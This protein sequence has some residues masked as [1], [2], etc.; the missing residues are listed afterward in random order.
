MKV[1]GGHAYPSVPG[2]VFGS[3]HVHAMCVDATLGVTLGPGTAA[4]PRSLSEQGIAAVTEE[5]AA[6]NVP[7]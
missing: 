2:T 1:I 3:L 5:A 7:V 4:I 6:A